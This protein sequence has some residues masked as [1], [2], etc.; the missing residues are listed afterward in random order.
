MSELEQVAA[1]L[2]SPVVGTRVL[3]GGF[4]HETSL[5]TLASGPVVVRIGD[6]DH[7]IEAAVMAAAR[8]HVPVPEVI[9]VLSV[10]SRSAMVL[11]YVV[12]TPLSEVL[13]DAGT[14][15][16]PLGVEVGRVA[17]AIGATTFDRP[18]FFADADLDVKPQ[19]PW[20]QQLPEFAAGCMDAVPA[21]RLDP[22]TR[23][24][25]AALCAGHAP[26]LAAV[27]DDARLV[28]ADL[29]P[30]NILVTRVRGGW[31]VDA[32]LDWEFSFSGC[33]YADAANMTRFGADYPSEFV[34]GFQSAFADEPAEWLYLGRVMDMF[35]LSDLVTRPAGNPVADRAAREIRRWVAESRR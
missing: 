27:D 12:G 23:T 1:A 11:E 5:L 15:L 34:A 24:A 18:G 21:A 6:T 8:R 32:V 29:N 31:R 30:K 10:G 16:G 28:H 17:A 35:A 4:S 25:W 13:D 3:A 9:D 26:A 7:A 2:G 14:D 22:A 19:I 33:P 20:S